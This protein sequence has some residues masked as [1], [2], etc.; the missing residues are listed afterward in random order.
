M[1]LQ[2]YLSLLRFDGTF[3]QVGAPEDGLPSIRP[4]AL[5]FK[6]INLTGSLIGS[7]SDIRDMLKLAVEKNVKPWV[8][9][10]PMKDANKAILDFEDGKPRYRYTLCNEE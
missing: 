7:P 6:R 10:I 4:F 5:I 2:E 8:Q 3:V 9:K 1:P